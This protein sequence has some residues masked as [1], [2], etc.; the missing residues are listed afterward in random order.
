MNTTHARPVEHLQALLI[1][2]LL[3]EV[4]PRRRL[5]CAQA[6]QSEAERLAPLLNDD[7][8]AELAGWL[9]RMLAR[10]TE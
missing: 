3:G 1:N 5:R 6:V 9:S 8:D 10:L 2:Q 7:Q 4:E